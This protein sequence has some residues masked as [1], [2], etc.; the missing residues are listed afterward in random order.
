MASF[1][2]CRGTF[3]IG[4]ETRYAAIGILPDNS[5]L[6]SLYLSLYVTVSRLI[7]TFSVDWNGTV[8][9]T[10][11]VYPYLT[12]QMMTEKNICFLYTVWIIGHSLPLSET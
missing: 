9:Y 8:N 6:L 5:V 11:V 4:I 3:I 7:L 1:S 12:R 2:A 10:G